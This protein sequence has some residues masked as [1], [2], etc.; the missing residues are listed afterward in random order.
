MIRRLLSS[1]G[2]LTRSPLISSLLFYACNLGLLVQMWTTGS[3]GGHSAL[4]WLAAF[5]SQALWVNYF[6]QRAPGEFWTIATA[7]GSLC[8][9]VVMLG[10]VLYLKQ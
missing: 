5:T 7:W 2:L 10:T 4:S 1:E 3:A 6:R 9:F 8:F